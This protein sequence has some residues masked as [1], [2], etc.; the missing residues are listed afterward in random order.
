MAKDERNLTTSTTKLLKEQ[1]FH[2]GFVFGVKRLFYGSAIRSGR[3]G[4][5]G[6]LYYVWRQM[7]ES[8]TAIEENSA[9][10]VPTI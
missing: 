3:I 6:I 9:A 5:A 1:V 2:K 4:C 8:V 7:V 10:A